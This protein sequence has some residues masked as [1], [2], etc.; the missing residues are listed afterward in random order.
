MVYG[1]YFVERDLPVALEDLH[2]AFNDLVRASA[3]GC[4]AEDAIRRFHASMA[5]VSTQARVARALATN[6]GSCGA[7]V[8]NHD[9]SALLPPPALVH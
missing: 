7:T 3:T 1:R 6:E 9:R 5:L 2:A 4:G 8:G